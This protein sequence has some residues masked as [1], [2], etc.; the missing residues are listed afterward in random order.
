MKLSIWFFYFFE[1]KSFID[2][3]YFSNV[4]IWSFFF[5]ILDTDQELEKKNIS[6]IEVGT[7]DFKLPLHYFLHISNFNCIFLKACLMKI[8]YLSIPHLKRIHLYRRN[9][10]MHEFENQTS[11][12][13]I[14]KTLYGEH[15]TLDHVFY[16]FLLP[17]ENYKLDTI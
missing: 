9:C 12:C 2:I 14:F 6:H 4:S 7:A 1:K 10:W 5:L 13:Q 16:Y 17:N 8:F 11:K 15:F 3:C